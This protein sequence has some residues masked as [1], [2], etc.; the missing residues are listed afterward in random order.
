MNKNSIF[1]CLGIGLALVASCGSK[2]EAQQ[3]TP[4]A[5]V[6]RVTTSVVVAEEV[7]R[8]V[9]YPGSVVP[10]QET[11]LRAEVSGYITHIFVADGASVSKGQRLYEIDRTRYSAAKDQAAANLAIARANLDKVQRDLAR[12]RSLDKQNAIAKQTL[13]YAETDLNN[14]KAQVASAEAAL[15]TAATNLNRSVITAPFSGT[16]GIAQVRSGALV[17]AGSTLLNTISST[18]PIGVDFAVNERDIALFAAMQQKGSVKSDAVLSLELP[19]GTIYPESGRII[20]IDRAVDS[21]TGT[22]MVRAQFDNHQG[23][24]R[25]GMNTNLRVLNKSA[26]AELVIPYKAVTEQLGESTV[27]VISDS[28]TAVQRK[29]KLGT[30]VAD[31]I[32]IKEGLQAGEKIVID[33][34]INLRQGDKITEQEQ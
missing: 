28:N 7:S 4:P 15:T 1:V 18:H 2:K 21:K 22:I 17:S 5:R 19:D 14:S 34:I 12:Y 23:N 30:K 33:G 11:E 20:A 10:L 9:S 16:I 3:Q 32:V 29:I 26:T 31:K 13:D 27:F 8:L 6:I 25:A 24:L